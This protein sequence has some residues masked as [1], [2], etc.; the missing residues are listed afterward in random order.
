MHNLLEMINLFSLSKFY[1][2]STFSEGFG[3]P[4]FKVWLANVY[5]YSFDGGHNDFA[6]NG[7]NAF[8]YDLNNS[9]NLI[10]ILNY[11]LALKLAI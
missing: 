2:S 6:I 9:D 11:S 5:Q 4:A 1:V 7:K 3:L 8:F 10:N